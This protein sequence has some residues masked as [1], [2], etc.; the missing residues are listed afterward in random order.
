LIRGNGVVATQRGDIL[1]QGDAGCLLEVDLSDD[2][3]VGDG[4]AAE[5]RRPC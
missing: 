3:G 2:T 5:G 1:D 4:V